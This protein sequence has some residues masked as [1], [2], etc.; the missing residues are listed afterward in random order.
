MKKKIIKI[1]STILGL[2]LAYYIWIL[3]TGLVI[4]CF[5][6][7]T[8]GLFCPGCGVT[9][10]FLSLLKLDIVG[11]FLYNPVAFVLFFV[12]NL[13][14]LFCFLGK[15]AFVQRPGFLYGSLYVSV[16]TLLIFGVL[17]NLY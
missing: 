4:P 6:L 8:T 1:Y 2:G 17:R 12:W 15:P 11:A 5:Y 10:M 3:V 7:K 13:I 9:R 16:G 14:A